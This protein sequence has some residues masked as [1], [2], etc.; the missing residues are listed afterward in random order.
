MIEEDI[1]DLET[2]IQKLITVLSDEQVRSL[3]HAFYS[4]DSCIK[5]TIE[6]ELQKR[7]MSTEIEFVGGEFK[8]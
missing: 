7:N 2:V 1:R 3:N 5:M 8:Y 6:E 4:Y